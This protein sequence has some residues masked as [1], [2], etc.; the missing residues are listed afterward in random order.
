[1][2]K[3]KLFLFI[4][5]CSAFLSGNIYAQA[6]GDYGSLATGNWGTTGANWVVCQ[7]AGQWTDAIAATV[8]PPSTVNVWIRNGHTITVEASGKVCNNITIETGATLTISGT[9]ATTIS[10]VF[11]HSIICSIKTTNVLLSDCA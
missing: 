4:L 3:T 11:I 9:N 2:R 5:I 8:V 10:G 6:V 1:M 7:T